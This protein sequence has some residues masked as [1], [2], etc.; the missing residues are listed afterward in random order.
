MSP[1]STSSPTRR[2]LALA[3]LLTAFLATAGQAHASKTQQSLFQDDRMLIAYGT[4][5]QNGALDDMHALGVDI[6]HADISWYMLAPSANSSSAPKGVDLSDPASYKASGWAIVDSLVRGVQ[7]RGMRLL[8]TP[9]APGPIWAAGSSCTKTERRKARLKGSCRTNASLYGK[10]VTALA[11]RYSGSY[12][13]P[14][15]PGS[16]PLPKVNLWSFWN[17]PNLSSWLY[18]SVV[19][20]GK[21]LVPV[22]ARYYRELVYAGGSALAGNGHGGDEV[23]LGETGPI[24]G[25]SSSLAPVPFYQALFCVDSKGRRLKG[26]AAKNLGCPKKIK[27]LPVTGDAHHAYTRATV[28]SLTAKSTGGNVSI[29]GISKLRSVLKQGAHVGAISSKASSSIQIT[30]FG[31]SSRPPSAKKYGL[32]LSKQAESINLFEYLAWRQSAIRSFA[33][34]QLEDD[35]LAAGS[36]AGRLVFQTGLRYQATNSQLMSGRLGTA[37]PSRAA[38]HVPLLVIDKGKNLI[39]W[40]G[41]HGQSTGSVQIVNSGKVVKTVSMH[42]GY[43]STTIKKRKGGWQLRFGGLR[44]RVASPVKV[45]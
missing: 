18:P 24:G 27:R 42:S 31:V 16:F 25:G 1:R 4:G 35:H 34:Y 17:E 41:V 45:P 11:K 23:W 13:D 33:Q 21:T 8:L 37:K 6:V 40:G 28:G 26:S 2:L 22:S 44:S 5:V 32:S 20:K 38:Y 36:H 19:R 30:E 29:S 14:S 12:V 15:Q 3:I 9:N 7:A 10:F 39:V 43:F